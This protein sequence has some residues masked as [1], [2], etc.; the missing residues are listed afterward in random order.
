MI[1]WFGFLLA[2]VAFFAMMMFWL[3]AEF[4]EALIIAGAVMALE[5]VLFIL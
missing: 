5:A 2:S 3:R 1:P 4:T